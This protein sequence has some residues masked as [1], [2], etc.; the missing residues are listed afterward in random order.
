MNKT[1]VIDVEKCTGCRLCELACSLE[2]EKNCNPARSRIH[3]LIWAEEGVSVPVVCCQCDDAPCVQVCKFEALKR[4]ASTGAVIVVEDNC[5]GCKMCMM[6]CP[7]GCIGY[8]KD[9][10]VVFKCELCEGDPECV[11]F[12]PTDAIRFIK[13]EK[14]S[15]DRKRSFAKRIAKQ[16]KP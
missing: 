4:D 10:H 2:H 16:Y 11:K 8:N 12:C 15:V 6:A 3:A 1:I 13:M 9:K 14:T 7:Y 5:I